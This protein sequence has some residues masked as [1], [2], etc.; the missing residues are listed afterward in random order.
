MR[1]SSVPVPGGCEDGIVKM[2]KKQVFKVCMK[3]KRCEKTGEGGQVGENKGCGPL[4]WPGTKML[5]FGMRMG[6][7]EGREGER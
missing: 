3:K 1:N 4:S 2:T 6:K 7:G 5:T